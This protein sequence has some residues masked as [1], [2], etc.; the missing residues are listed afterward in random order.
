MFGLFKFITQSSLKSGDV[1]YLLEDETKEEFVVIEKKGIN[2]GPVGQ[3]P[4]SRVYVVH[5]KKGSEWQFRRDA[6]VLKK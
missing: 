1:V 5:D 2:R 4:P 3:F 6:L